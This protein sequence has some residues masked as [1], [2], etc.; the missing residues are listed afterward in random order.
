VTHAISPQDV[1]EAACVL[2]D[3]RDAFPPGTIYVVV[4]DPEVGSARQLVVIRDHR[5]YFV[6]P[7]NGVFSLVSTAPDSQAIRLDRP[8][9]WRSPVSATFHGR[10]IMAPIAAYLANGWTWEHLGSP[11]SL[12]VL[13]AFPAPTLDVASGQVEG[14]VEYAD[15]FGNLM[16]N[17]RGGNL[18]QPAHGQWSVSCGS[19]S[20]IPLVR[21]YADRPPGTIVALMGSSDRL[22]VAIV[23]GNAQTEL[24]VPR[25][26]RVTCSVK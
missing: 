16:T 13:L 11:T 18:P 5:H 10:D 14:R 24:H 23:G 1:E 17:I 22:E 3:V 2:A 8:G 21:C 4:V 12:R 15:R 19:A 20:G 26:A 6:G 7:D 25:H 9:F